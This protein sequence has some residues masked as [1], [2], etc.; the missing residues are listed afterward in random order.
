METR[1]NCLAGEHYPKQI[2][3]R[4]TDE[5][6]QPTDLSNKFVMHAMIICVMGIIIIM[7]SWSFGTVGMNPFDIDSYLNIEETKEQ[8]R[9]LVLDL[10]EMS[11]EDQAKALAGK[12]YSTRGLISDSYFANQEYRYLCLGVERPTPPEVNHDPRVGR[13]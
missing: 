6:G 10:R 9:K 3:N 1:H 5:K 11:C 12:E 2:P 7:F 8:K 13:K 4:W